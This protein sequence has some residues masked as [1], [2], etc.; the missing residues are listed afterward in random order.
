MLVNRHS[1]M[2]A[3]HP[4]AGCL[5]SPPVT[6]KIG[7]GAGGLYYK[8]RREGGGGVEGQEEEEKEGH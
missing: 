1:R 8:A 7:Q 5:P 3:Y 2:R 4:L 6:S